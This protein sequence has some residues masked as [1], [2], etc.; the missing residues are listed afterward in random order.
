MVVKSLRNHPYGGKIRAKGSIYEIEN[1][2]HLKTLIAVRAV[3]IHNESTVKSIAK[4]VDE[5]KDSD[6][7]VV[8][9]FS[10]Q[11]TK[12]MVHN[13]E[14]KVEGPDKKEKR[15]YRKRNFYNTKDINSED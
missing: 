13:L 14:Q 9:E 6:K 12:A 8:K 4:P 10:I 3:S 7:N 1:K 5:I 2:S 11:S 15:K